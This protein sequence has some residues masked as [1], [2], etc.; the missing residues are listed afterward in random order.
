M[1]NRKFLTVEYYTYCETILDT[2]YKNSDIIKCKVLLWEIVK[3]VIR[4]W[5]LDK[6]F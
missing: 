3:V 2:S 6:E 1:F 4:Q 5:A